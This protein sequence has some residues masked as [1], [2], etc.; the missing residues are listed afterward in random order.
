MKH[1]ASMLQGRSLTHFLILLRFEFACQKSEVMWPLALPW[2]LV[3][4]GSMIGILRGNGV[5]SF[6][7]GLF[8]LGLVL[9][10]WTALNAWRPEKEAPTTAFYVMIPVTTFE[11]Y[12]CRCVVTLLMP[13]GVGLLGVLF[14]QFTFGLLA[15]L[16]SQRV[17]WETLVPSLRFLLVFG[18]GYFFLH[19]MFFWG[20]LFF[21]KAAFLKT[22][23]TFVFYFG[24]LGILALSSAFFGLTQAVEKRFEFHFSLENFNPEQFFEVFSAYGVLAWGVVFPFLLHFATFFRLKEFEVN[25]L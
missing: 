4:L 20:G 14:L 12:L 24:L 6:P 7:S 22:C 3:S 2:L 18:L 21:R 13:F 19:S 23:F 11:K 9:G 10:L 8:L 15:Q 25:Q 5:D 1:L 16:M 17:A